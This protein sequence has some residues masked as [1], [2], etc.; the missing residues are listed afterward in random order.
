MNQRSCPDDDESGAPVL[1][2]DL[3]RATGT[4]A[5]AASVALSGSRRP[6]REAA[7]VNGSDGVSIKLDVR[8]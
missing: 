4:D 5:V 7:W 1:R 2:W 3:V 6:A 8:T